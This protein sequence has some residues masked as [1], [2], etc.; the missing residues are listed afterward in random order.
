MRPNQAIQPHRSNR[1]T[2]PRVL[3][4][5]YPST[6]LVVLL[7]QHTAGLRRIWADCMYHPRPQPAAVHPCTTP[8]RRRPRPASRPGGAQ[9]ATSM[10]PKRSLLLVHNV[11]PHTTPYANDCPSARAAYGLQLRPPTNI[12]TQERCHLGESKRL[13][14]T[15]KLGS[16]APAHQGSSPITTRP[17]CNVLGAAPQPPFRLFSTQHTPVVQPA[18]Y[19]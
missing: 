15:T 19:P 17:W 6:Q 18:V 10:L 14:P 8:L 13:R 4:A 16:N 3:P 12:T 7:A 11:S 5:A 2:P 9:C 1:T